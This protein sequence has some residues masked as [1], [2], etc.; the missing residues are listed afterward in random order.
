MPSN[1]RA[2]RGRQAL[3]VPD[4]LRRGDHDCRSRAGG[5]GR[6]AGHAPGGRAESPSSGVTWAG[7]CRATRRPRGRA[8]VNRP[9]PGSA[10][11]VATSA[12]SSSRRVTLTEA[13]S[14]GRET[15][16]WP[17][18]GRRASPPSVRPCG[19]RCAQPNRAAPTR[20]HS[21]R[22]LPD[23]SRSLPSGAVE[24]FLMRSSIGSMFSAT[25]SSSIALSSANDPAPLPVPA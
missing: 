25:A 3:Q 24:S 10:P 18:R 2:R 16:R 9:V 7:G 14:G 4:H 19:V 8:P 6:T 17:R 21:S 11:L 12:V 22:C 23:H 13:G 20:K 5:T 1:W 15:W